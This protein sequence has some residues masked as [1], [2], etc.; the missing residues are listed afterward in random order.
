MLCGSSTPEGRMSRRRR[1]KSVATGAAVLVAVVG[2]AAM[3][4][5]SGTQRV[6]QESAA[7]KAFAADHGSAAPKHHAGAK[8]KLGRKAGTRGGFRRGRTSG[9]TA[10]FLNRTTPGVYIV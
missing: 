7:A 9:G 5:V 4:G 1:L 6:H 10:G 3:A 2:L 8:A